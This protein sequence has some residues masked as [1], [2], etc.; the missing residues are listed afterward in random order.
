MRWQHPEQWLV[1]PAKFIPIAEETG[2]IVPIGQWVLQ[3]ACQQV[4]VWQTM[5]YSDLRIVVNLSARQFQQPDLRRNL[6]DVF[7][8]TSLDPKYLDLELTESTVVQNPEVA[9]AT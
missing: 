1:S 4:Q 3:T 2:L 8:S 9:I 7:Q 6:V 5:G